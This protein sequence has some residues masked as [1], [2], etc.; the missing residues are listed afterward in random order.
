MSEQTQVQQ[1]TMKGLKKVE[2]GKRLAEWNGRKR[3]ERAQ[4]AKVQNEPNLTYHGAGAIIAIGALGIFGYYIYKSKK[5]PKETPVHQTN[6]TMVNQ[7]DVTPAH[8]FEM[9]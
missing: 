6:E 7:S 2:G 5:T 8:K 1:V 3:Q 9:E 4:L